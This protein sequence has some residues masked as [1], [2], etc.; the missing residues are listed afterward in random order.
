MFSWQF[1]L[2]LGRN[3]ST[4]TFPANTPANAWLD[5]K[6]SA[7]NR[8]PA[9]FSTSTPSIE[10][11]Y[12]RELACQVQERPFSRGW[13]AEISLEDA[14]Q[15]TC[16]EFVVHSLQH[17]HLFLSKAMRKLQ[18]DFTRGQ[19]EEIA[20]CNL[21][22]RDI[23]QSRRWQPCRV[24]DHGVRRGGSKGFVE[25]LRRYRSHL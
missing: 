10:Q 9:S 22:P 20:M 21:S 12:K 16:R 3:F 4:S 8:L 11:C 19:H 7:S 1:S 13:R 6:A 15:P 18:A 17:S 24:G 14:P 2:W 25:G 23:G 5:P